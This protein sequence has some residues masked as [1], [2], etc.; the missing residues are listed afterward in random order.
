MRFLW[1][2][3]ENNTIQLLHKTLDTT[4]TEERQISRLF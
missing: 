3:W 2:R 4:D 1:V